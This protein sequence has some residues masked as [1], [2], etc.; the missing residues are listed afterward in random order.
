LVFLTD[1][2]GAFPDNAPAYPVLWAS[3][4]GRHAPFGSV[5]PMCAA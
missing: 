1:L 4:G 2:Y 5:I 3:T